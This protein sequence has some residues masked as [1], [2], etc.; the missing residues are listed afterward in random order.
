M[1]ATV[2]V[3]WSYYSREI[4]GLKHLKS[5]A[6]RTDKNNDLSMSRRRVGWYKPQWT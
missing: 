5:H 2:V 4:K 1:V 3:P 6:K